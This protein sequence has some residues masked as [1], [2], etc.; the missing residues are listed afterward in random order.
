M[1]LGRFA[2][3]HSLTSTSVLKR[4]SSFVIHCILLRWSGPPPHRALMW[5]TSQPGQAPRLRPVAGQGLWRMKAKRSA[6]ER[7]AA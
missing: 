1:V 7:W 2:F 5:S 3:L 4:W 6:A